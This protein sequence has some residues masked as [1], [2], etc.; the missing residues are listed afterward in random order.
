MP[1]ACD[2]DWGIRPVAGDG[3]SKTRGRTPQGRVAH[4]PDKPSHPTHREG[5][6]GKRHPAPNLLGLSFSLGFGADTR[7]PHE[8]HVK[9]SWCFTERNLLRTRTRYWHSTPPTGSCRL[10]GQGSVR[11][12]RHILRCLAPS[13]PSRVCEKVRSYSPP[14][15]DKSDKQSVRRWVARLLR[16]GFRWRWPS[17]CCSSIG[18]STSI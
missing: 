5:S 17:R 12:S 9:E 13:P 11:A 16:G 15:D 8:L 6:G 3:R 4:C 2:R 1:A 7:L 18:R 10:R 14:A